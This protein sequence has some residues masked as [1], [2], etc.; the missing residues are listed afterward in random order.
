MDVVGISGDFMFSLMVVAL[1]FLMILA[2]CLFA[3]RSR[4]DSNE[5]FAEVL[6]DPG[7]PTAPETVALPAL[8]ASFAPV[9]AAPLTGIGALEAEVADARRALVMAEHDVLAAEARLA[10]ARARQ[11]ADH[12]A[13]ASRAAAQAADAAVQAQQS[14]RME[15]RPPRPPM[16]RYDGPI[17]DGSNL[18]ET[19]PSMD[20]PRSRQSRRAA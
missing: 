18:P 4:L 19:H 7:M 1:F 5:P 11:A 12:A 20:F 13:L 16:P 17:V 15:P 10:M 9:A 6:D 14:A 2:P 8:V 3:L